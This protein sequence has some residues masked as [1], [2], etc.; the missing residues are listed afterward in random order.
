MSSLKKNS[1]LGRGLSA[2]LDDAETDITTSEFRPMG[3]VSMIYINQIEANPFQPRTEFDEAL[4][5]ELSESIKV[6]GL[7]QPVTVRKMGYDKFQLISGERRTRAAILAGLD[8][9]PA[10]VRVANDQETLEMALIENIQRADLNAVEVALSYKRL[11]EECN[12]KQE[13][14]GERVGKE[15]STVNNYLRLL[16]LPDEIQLAIKMGIISMGHARAIV[17]VSDTEAQM[18]IF[19]RMVDENLSVRNVE[20]LVKSNKKDVKEP[21]SKAKKSVL[22]DFQNDAKAL[23]DKLNVPVQIK[24][25]AAGKGQLILKFNNP[26]ELERILRKL[27]V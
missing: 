13:E 17:N 15:R 20:T 16:R 11:I 27:D 9:I 22:D 19:R 4:L 1:G 24:G 12:L 7:I 8:K 26:R 2:L 23:E 25:N 14:L 5:K 21:V 6:H 18:E 3:S 10:Y